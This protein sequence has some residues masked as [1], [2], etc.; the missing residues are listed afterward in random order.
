MSDK[1]TNYSTKCSRCDNNFLFFLFLIAQ[2][3]CY[4]RFFP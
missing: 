4:D 3:L 1:D 2:K